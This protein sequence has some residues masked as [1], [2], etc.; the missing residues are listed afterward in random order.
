MIA[1]PVMIYA[2]YNVSG[3]GSNSYV[4]VNVRSDAYLAATHGTWDYKYS[5]KNFQH[6]FNKC[7]LRVEL[8]GSRV[9]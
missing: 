4:A 2:L 5:N 6:G 3:E 8:L 7:K 1:T 9:G